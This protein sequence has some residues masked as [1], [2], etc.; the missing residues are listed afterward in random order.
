MFV[1]IIPSESDLGQ[2]LSSLNF[3]IRVR[4]VE[5]G[6]AR[7]QVDTG[8][9]QKLKT[10]LEK[11]RQEARSKDELVR[12][13]EDSLQNMESKA[14]SCDHNHRNLQEQIRELKNL[15][16]MKAASHGQSEKQLLQLSER[17]RGKEEN[18]VSLQHKVREL[19]SKLREL[20]SKL[21]EGEQLESAAYEQKELEMKLKDKVQ[22]SE[23]NSLVLHRKIKEPEKRL[24]DHEQNP[25]IGFLQLKVKELEEQLRRSKCLPPPEAAK[26]RPNEAKR[27][28]RLDYE[29][30]GLVPE[31]E[32][33]ELDDREPEP[34]SS[35]WDA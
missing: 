32:E 10:M 28:E 25:E 27:A 31:S 13:L 3:A 7:K 29:Q 11:A 16:E 18:C 22:E 12:K 9:I 24:R 23:Y 19:E 33:L 5:L 6:P 20:E 4:R 34:I 2:T 8:E 26:A 30:C 14:R 15:L 1:Q 21:R 17:L 35:G